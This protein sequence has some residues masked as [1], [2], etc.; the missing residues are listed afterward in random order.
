MTR[1]FESSAENQ[2]PRHSA[3]KRVTVLHVLE[4]T[5]AGAA[6][7]VSDV[8]LN[9]DLDAFEVSLVFS[10]IR[11]DARFREDLERMRQRGI[12]TFEISMTR[13]INP[14]ADGRA[15]FQLYRLLRRTRF[16]IV[17]CHSSKAG[18][19]GRIAAK[20]AHRKTVTLYS[21]HAIAIS[22][23]RAYWYL[24][25]LAAPF[26]D[27][28]VGVTA[29]E[30]DQLAEYGLVPPSKL[31]FIT[32]AI[33]VAGCKRITGHKSLL[34]Q[35]RI[36]NDVVVV[37]AAGRLAP[38]KD[39]FTFL[40]VV[41][42]IRKKGLPAHFLW[43]G[44]GELR[45]QVFSQARKMGIEDSITFTGYCQDLLPVLSSIDIFALTS[46]YESFGYVTCEAMALS[47]PVVGTNV[48]G[49][50]ELVVDGT[51]GFLVEPRDPEAFAERLALLIQDPSLRER[52]GRAGRTRAETEYDLSRMI[53]EIQD[54]YHK[55]MATA[56]ANGVRPNVA[57]REAVVGRKS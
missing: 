52:M 54:F 38:Q 5:S 15:F 36:P 7:Y 24:E 57:L 23:N 31:N 19:L 28:M 39:P 14:R 3:A 1:G 6:R 51:T 35:F 17:H 4:S 34:S 27:A 26:T 20:V 16:D 55:L 18:F 56:G 41:D 42:I 50:K 47:K 2:P 25:K 46:I 8:L 11:S 37:G 9:L 12:A 53:G 40:K 21:P 43:I 30:R 48:A 13:G 33:D 29:S 44:D 45:E 32:A 22:V 49:T 10:M